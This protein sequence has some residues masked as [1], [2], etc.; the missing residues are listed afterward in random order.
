[1]TMFAVVAVPAG[2]TQP[3][4]TDSLTNRKTTGS[5]TVFNNFSD[6]FMT[7]YQG[8]LRVGK[9][10]IH[11]MLISPANTAGMYLYQYLILTRFRSLHIFKSKRFARFVQYHSLHKKIYSLNLVLLLDSTVSSKYGTFQIS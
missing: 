8:E 7:G 5:F 10:P 2:M 4:N 1:M 6:N 3:W 11:N 9:F